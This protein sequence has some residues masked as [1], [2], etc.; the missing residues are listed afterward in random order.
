MI[1]SKLCKAWERV[2]VLGWFVLVAVPLAHGQAVP[3]YKVDP[4][5]PKALPNNWIIWN[6]TGLVVDKDDHIWVQHHPSQLSAADAGAAFN[7]PT[8]ECCI[9]APTYIQFD[10]KGDVLKSW[11]G[12]GY[13]PDWPIFEHGLFIDKQ[14]NFWFG[15]NF[16]G[17]DG[18]NLLAAI[19]KP[20]ELLADRHGDLRISTVS[21]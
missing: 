20:K 4:S 17:G 5:W 18:A 6:S 19:P 7:P 15:G 14:G 1:S 21:G 3:R 16:A 9:P 10:A 8:A 12:P 11:G 13:V 2:F